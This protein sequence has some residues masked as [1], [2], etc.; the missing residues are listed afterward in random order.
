M[1]IQMALTFVVYFSPT[2]GGAGV[3]ESLSLVVMA[4]FVP[5]GFV[6]YYNLLWRF[7]T[8][9]VWAIA[10]GIFLGQAVLRSTRSLPLIKRP[11]GEAK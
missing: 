8:I 7:T 5:D 4:S 10:G 6:P 3:A 9:Y 2:P 1:G 11:K